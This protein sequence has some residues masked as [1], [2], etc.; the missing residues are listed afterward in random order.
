VSVTSTDIQSATKVPALSQCLGA[1]AAVVASTLI[2]PWFGKPRAQQTLRSF[3]QQIKAALQQDAE[4]KD[5]QQRAPNSLDELLD[6]RGD[7]SLFQEAQG[8]I[9]ILYY[10]P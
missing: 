4:I 8:W 2:L 1:L 6:A 9:P 3:Q 10:K 5:A 7:V